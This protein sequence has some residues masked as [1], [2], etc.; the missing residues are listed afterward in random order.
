MISIFHDKNIFQNN[1]CYYYNYSLDVS[2]VS[3]LPVENRTKRKSNLLQVKLRNI[4]L[5][6]KRSSKSNSEPPVTSV[7]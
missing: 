5:L 3:S 4:S 7:S 2:P 1:A 6:T